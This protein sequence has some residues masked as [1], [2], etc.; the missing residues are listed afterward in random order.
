MNRLQ[1][2]SSTFFWSWESEVGELGFSYPCLSFLLLTPVTGF[3]SP[4]ILPL[5]SIF[6]GN[7]LSHHLACYLN[8]TAYFKLYSLPVVS[9]LGSGNWIFLRHHP[10]ANNFRDGLLVLGET[11][12]LEVRSAGDSGPPT[13]LSGSLR[14]RLATLVSLSCS[15][16]AVSHLH[17]FALWHGLSV[18]FFLEAPF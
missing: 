11:L 10:H 5:V 15:R 13:A 2:T 12:T 17:T 6:P 14:S 8:S 9:S 4:V 16:P 18:Q 1:I 3:T 7:S